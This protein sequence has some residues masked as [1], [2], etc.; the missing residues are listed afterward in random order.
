MHMHDILG[1]LRSHRDEEFVNRGADELL[2]FPGSEFG[3]SGTTFTVSLII[4]L[5]LEV[6]GN[7]KTFHFNFV[8]QIKAP[9]VDRPSCM[10]T[11]SYINTWYINIMRKTLCT[12]TNQTSPASKLPFE[13]SSKNGCWTWLMTRI[14]TMYTYTCVLYHVSFVSNHL[15]HTP[16]RSPLTSPSAKNPAAIVI[17]LYNHCI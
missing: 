5:C 4:V 1:W 17:N 14:N 10:L 12:F 16:I 3:I 6:L 9:E 7:D 8:M 13:S 15:P 11:C 2:I